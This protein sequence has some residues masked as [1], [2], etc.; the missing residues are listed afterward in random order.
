MKDEAKIKDFE[1]YRDNKINDFYV[2]K[3]NKTLIDPD[4]P[5]NY[6]K[7]NYINKQN[8]DA[9]EAELAK[10]KQEDF[11]RVRQSV[12]NSVSPFQVGGKKPKSDAELSKNYAGVSVDD[13]PEC[14][15]ERV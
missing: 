7:L 13:L 12:I 9:K 14:Q 1:T 4:N 15:A 6:S 5:V 2:N 11:D 3:I 8:K 10:N